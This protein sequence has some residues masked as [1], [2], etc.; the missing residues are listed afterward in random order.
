[1]RILASLL[2][3][4]FSAVLLC[5]CRKES[6]LSNQCSDAGLTQSLSDPDLVIVQPNGISP[7]GDGMNDRFTVIAFSKANPQVQQSF[8]VQQLKVMR[9][10][11]SLPV[12]DNPDYRNTFDGHDS[13]GQELP[14]GNYRYTLTLDANTLQG[15]LKIIR[16]SK[17]C[18]CRVIDV[19]DTYFMPA[20]P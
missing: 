13:A 7:N 20:C 19:Q 17:A 11:G 1:M 16:T 9:P 5:G 6:A 12:Y 15:S 10:V 14:E 2:V 8:A 3:L 4:S 18:S